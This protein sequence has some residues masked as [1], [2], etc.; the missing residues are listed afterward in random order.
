MFTAKQLCEKIV[1]LYP[2]IGVCGIDIDVGRNHSEKAWIVHLEKGDYRLNHF[3]EF[4]DAN[5]CME[6]RECV[7]LGLD[8]A[9]L[10]KNMV[11]KQF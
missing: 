9:Q 7:A 3:L 4:K 5:R 6:G 10:Q 11:G 8:I 2:E 1:N